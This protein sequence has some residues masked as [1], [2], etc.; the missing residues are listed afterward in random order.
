MPDTFWSVQDIAAHD[1]DRRSSA[2]A[3][4]K[5]ATQARTEKKRSAKTAALTT[6]SK[7][8]TPQQTVPIAKTSSLK[9]A[10]PKV[11]EV[12]PGPKH[13]GARQP[14]QQPLAPLFDLNS[15]CTSAPR[16]P[17][18]RTRPRLFGLEHCP[19]FYP[20]VEEFMRPMEYIEK[21]AREASHEHGI[22]KIV[23]PEGWRPPFA[24]DT[25]VRP[26]APLRA[27]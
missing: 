24:L 7:S 19:I 13:N 18:E 3:L 15:V 1:N 14:G 4:A 17:P 23:P 22:A 5:A 26:P 12:V 11:E 8:S 21:V 16:V 27:M 6:L 20:S 10:P 25:R 2:P 9:I